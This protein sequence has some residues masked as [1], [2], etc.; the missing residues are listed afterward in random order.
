MDISNLNEKVK[1]LVSYLQ[2]TGYSAMYI[3]Y[4]KKMVKW[5]SE[6]SNH[7]K[8]TSLSE[9][10]Q[11]LKELWPNRYTCRNKVRL[12]RIIRQYV[13]KGIL[14]DGHKHYISP[15]HYELLVEEYRKITDVAFRIVDKRCKSSANVKYALSSFFFHLQEMRMYSLESITEDAVLE[16]FSQDGKL[17]KSHSRKY[18]VEYG[19]KACLPH[20]GR[21]VER[22]IAY[23]PSIPNKRKNIQYLTELELAAIKHTLETTAQY[24]YRTKP[25]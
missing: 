8:W 6:N 19:L 16:L 9:A 17:G 3:D 11:T 4:V 7:Y 22:I 1:G 13:E 2:D 10:A 15:H 5:L 21:S 25:S 24:P 20:Y 14:P 12:L 23:L 18:T